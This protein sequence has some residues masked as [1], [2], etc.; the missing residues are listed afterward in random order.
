MSIKQEILNDVT[1]HRIMH[2]LHISDGGPVEHR[3]SDGEWY[4]IY[5]WGEDDFGVRHAPA[6]EQPAQPRDKSKSCHYC[7]MPATDFNFFDAPV[8]KECN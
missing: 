3:A 7:G 2:L 8:C 1:H 6:V 5:P 4:E